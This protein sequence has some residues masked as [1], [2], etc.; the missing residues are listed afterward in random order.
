MA[1]PRIAITIGDPA[2]IGPEICEKALA[3]PEIKS[4]AHY[5]VIGDRRIIPSRLVGQVSA[6]AGKASVEYVEKAI[7]LA[8]HG[9]VDAIVTCPISKEAIHKAGYKYQG[10]TEILAA[11]TKTKNYAMLFVAKPFWVMLVTI[12]I[13]LKDVSRSLKKSEVLRIIK[14]AHATLLKAGIK[15]P[16]IG[17][18]G[19]NP[20]AGENGILGKEE[21]KIIT[22]AVAVAKKA[23]INATGPISP[24]AIFNQARDG[25]FDLVVAMYHDQGLIPLKLLSFGKAVNVTAGL[26]FV[27][28]SVDHGTG[29]DIA[30]KNLARPDSLIEAIKVAVQLVHRK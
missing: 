11:R 8:L 27:R 20:H 5:I 29:F 13:P 21:I 23:G 4:L 19:L 18:A 2:G 3:K 14:L 17:V 7:E 24:D 10:H 22:P 12:H 26:P 9:K 6:T 28:T 1:K 15:Q 25:K 16:R 30:G